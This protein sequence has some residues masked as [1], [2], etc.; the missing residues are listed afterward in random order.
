MEENELYKLY[1]ESIEYMN[2]KEYENALKIAEKIENLKKYTPNNYAIC[3]GLY[4]DL[5]LYER[6]IDTIEHGVELLETHLDQ[7]LSNEKYAQTTYYN[8]ANGYSNI[9]KFKK[10]ENEFYGI[11]EETELNIA[12]DYYFKALKAKQVDKN[13]T[14]QILVNIGNTLDQMGR[15]LEAIEYYNK[16]LNRNN[17]FGMALGNKGISLK[18]YSRIVRE[19]WPIYYSESYFLLKKAIKC[20]DVHNEARVKF[21]NHIKEIEKNVDI[22]KLEE[23]SNNRENIEMEADSE[24][25]EFLIQFCLENKLYLNLCNLCQKCKIAI[26]DNIAIKKMIVETDSGGNPS[27]EDDPFLKV[28]SFLNEIKQNYVTARFLLIQSRYPKLNL[29]FVDKNVKIIDTFDYKVQNVYVQLLKFAFKNMYDILDKIAIFINEYLNLGKNQRYVSF[30]NIWKENGEFNP[31]I[32][33]TKNYNL[34]ALYQIKKD[35][36]DGRFKELRDIRNAVTHRF[37]GV[38][39]FRGEKMD[40]ELLVKKTIEMSQLVK[41]AIIYLISFVDVEE[42]KKE[43]EI[44]D[45]LVPMNVFE[46]PDNLKS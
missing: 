21:K 19:K 8:L 41:R 10:I 15:S 16:V 13:N 25:E 18:Y 6:S 32:K 38:N 45:L 11:F 46:V 37:M 28:S 12:L 17:R 4:I 33:E 42:R 7:F 29:D 31:K 35:L 9:F 22:N 26:G 36:G 34:N 1:K 40:E 5:G 27:I 2:K 44:E 14:L 20:D 43:E 24:F 3:S 30:S 23:I 39:M